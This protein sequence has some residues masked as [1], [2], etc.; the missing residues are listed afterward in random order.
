M[1]RMLATIAGRTSGMVILRN[2]A[3]RV[4]PDMSA[5]S[6]REGSIDRNAAT[7]SRKTIG[8]RCRPS[9][10]IIPQRVKTSKTPGPKTGSRILLSS[11]ISG[12]ARKIQATV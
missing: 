12:L 11:P 3:Q 2:V 6:S 5:D 10:Q 7:I 9:T 1:I 4:A 8:E